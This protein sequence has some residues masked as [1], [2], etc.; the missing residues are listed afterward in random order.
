MSH[1]LD[2]IDVLT[3]STTSHVILDE[4]NVAKGIQV[5]RFGNSLQYF[6]SKEVVLSA[7]AIGTPQ[8]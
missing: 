2:N 5:Q 3:Y 7:G 1:N 8:E 4:A 6:A